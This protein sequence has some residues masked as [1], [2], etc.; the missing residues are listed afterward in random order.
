LRLIKVMGTLFLVIMFVAIGNAMADSNQAPSVV[1]L[2]VDK[3][4]PQ[5][6]G[7]KITWTAQASDSENDPISYRF[8]LDGQPATDWQPQNQWT[9]T[10]TEASV[11]DNQVEVRIIDGKHAG[12][13]RFDAYKTSSFVIN[14]PSQTPAVE[15]PSVLSETE[16][17]MQKLNKGSSVC[18]DYTLSPYNITFD[19]GGMN[20]YMLVDYKCLERLESSNR[21]NKPMRYG[22]ATGSTILDIRRFRFLPLPGVSSN[23][24]DHDYLS[25]ISLNIQKRS[26]KYEAD[27]NVAQTNNKPY[28]AA[29][30]LG[31]GSTI[32][33]VQQINNVTWYSYQNRDDIERPI[34]RINCKFEADLTPAESIRIE[35]ENVSEP[36]V[37]QFMDSLRVAGLGNATVEESWDQYVERVR[38]P[39]PDNPGITALEFIDKLYSIKVDYDP[40]SGTIYRLVYNGPDLVLSKKEIDEMAIRY[41]YYGPIP[42]PKNVSVNSP[43]GDAIA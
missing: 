25:K 26:G 38:E 42:L 22:W 16:N 2:V 18:G 6:A 1:R 20:E 21:D 17:V 28:V 13:D 4:S 27:K 12:Q 34:P 11:G 14:V 3:G 8:F 36:I 7:S 41:K 35:F 9:W 29:M 33:D 10:T 15:A 31:V 32:Y 24:D 30:S 40:E 37:N 23:F 5:D 43:N 19:F 39:S